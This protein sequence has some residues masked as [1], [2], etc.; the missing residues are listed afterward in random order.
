MVNII[1]VLIITD[2]ILAEE[3]SKV[4]LRKLTKLQSYIPQKCNYDPGPYRLML[5]LIVLK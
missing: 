2:E 3:I 5:I 4:N 1:L